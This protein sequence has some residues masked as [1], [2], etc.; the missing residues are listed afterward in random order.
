M[1]IFSLHTAVI[2]C[3]LLQA[4]NNGSIR[5]SEDIDKGIGFGVTASYRCNVQGLGLSGGVIMRTC[6]PGGD[7]AGQWDGEA[8][9]CERE[10]RD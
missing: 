5:Y 1:H 10:E 8:P 2:E 4:P 7:N 6:G 9:S 3:P